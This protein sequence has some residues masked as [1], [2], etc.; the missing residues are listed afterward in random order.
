MSIKTKVDYIIVGQGLAG[1]C[2]ALQLIGR[3]KKIVVFD[4]PEKNRASS[5]AAGLFNPVTGK[6]LAKS[7]N[8][9]KIFSCL[10]QFYSDAEKLLNEKFFYPMP[11]YCPFVSVEEQNEWMSIS[12]DDSLSVFIEKVFTQST[13]KQTHDPF[14]GFLIRQS[15]YVDVRL[16]MASVRKFLKDSFHQEHFDATK[17]EVHYNEIEYEN[18][19]ADAIIFCDG[20]N[21]KSNPFFT[22]LPVIPL[23]GETLS[24][25]LSENPEAIFNRGVYL[26]P[27][28]KN[29][30]FK[31]G[32]TYQPNDSLQGITENARVELEDKLNKLTT[33]SF[34]IIEQDW[35][36][37]PSTRDRKPIIG[38]HLQHKN[39]LAFNGLGTKGVSLSPYFSNVIADWLEGKTEIPREVNIKRFKT[40][41]SKFSI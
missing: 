37:R 36:I 16:F 10:F 5:V 32:A 11:I 24:I 35:G 13:F 26:V 9:D 27:D 20:M 15:G 18:I 8:A 3:G 39:V 28:I 41:Y 30:S 40:L 21:A 25:T 17:V 22:D 6:R 14:G 34:Q 12:P 1:S 7:W 31:V 4:E 19:C 23:K 29:N 33:I 38:S 2:M